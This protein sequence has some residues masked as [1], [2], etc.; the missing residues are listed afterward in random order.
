V[1]AG[2]NSTGEGHTLAMSSPVSRPGALTAVRLVHTAAW[3]VLGACAV[4]IGPFA[5]VGRLRV[6]AALSFVVFLEVLILAFNQWRCP[7]TPIAARYT[8]DRR[9]NF[10]IYLPEW[11]AKYNKEIFGTIYVIGLLVLIGRWTG[12]L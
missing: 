4:A 7:L 11:L 5:W 8:D 12:W 3:V 2:L 1:A 6:A 10:D 9:P